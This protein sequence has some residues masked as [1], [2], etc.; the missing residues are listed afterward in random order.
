MP[1]AAKLI[2]MTQMLARYRLVLVCLL[3]AALAALVVLWRNSRPVIIPTPHVQAVVLDLYED[4]AMLPYKQFRDAVAVNDI[5]TLYAL[6]DGSSYLSYRSSL[7]LARHTGIAASERVRFYERAASLRVNEPLARQENREFMLELALVSEQAGLWDKAI[8]AYEDALPEDAAIAALKR[9]QT[10]PYTLSNV[11]L[12]A[13]LYQDSIDALAGRSAPSI[14]APAYRALGEHTKA[15]D[16]YERWQIEQPTNFTAR[17]GIAWSHFYLANNDLADQLFTGLSGSSAAYGR[18]LIAKRRGNLPQAVAFM[19]QSGEANHLWL[20][21]GWL[22]AQDRYAEA[23]PVYLQLARTGA[24]NADDAAYRAMVLAKRLGQT[25]TAEQAKAL[26]PS[27]AFFGSKVGKVPSFPTTTG[28]PLI[29]LPVVDLANK[30]SAVGDPDAAVGELLFALRNAADATTIIT[31]AETLQLHGEFRQSSLAA[32]RLISSGSQDIRV[33]RVAYPQAY[34]QFVQTAAAQYGLEPE[35][36]WAVMRQE[37]AFYPLA[38]S[39]SNAKGLMQFIPSTWDWVAELLKE[40]PQD[41]FEPVHNIRYG[42]YYL[43]YLLDYFNGDLELAVPSYNGGQGYIRR[44]FE[45]D[46]VRQ[47]KDEFYREIDRTETREY[48]QSVLEHYEVYK[49]LY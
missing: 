27:D 45:G 22:E 2:A 1:L 7:N 32:R 24:T 44:L 41:P 35:L 36:M 17:S 37:S 42:A 39:R 31:L 19:Q 38:V 33:W 5:G 25:A 9:L 13:R 49:A 34:P 20:A 48:L 8:A 18:G 47:N 46:V 23:I 16:A 28:L 11:F 6:A 3:V 40:N 29:T 4:P 15:L 26:L 43:R 10:N 21:T 12:Q 30:L 14:E